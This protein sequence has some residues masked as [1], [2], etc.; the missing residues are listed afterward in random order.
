MTEPEKELLSLLTED[1]YGLWEVEVWL[2]VG[3]DTL[4]EIVSSLLR[5]QLIEWFTRE[6]DSA[7]AVALSELTET[8][9]SLEDPTAWVWP[10]RSERQYL[11]ATTEAGENVYFGSAVP[12]R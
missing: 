2:P 7:N 4:R 8:P 6:D 5:Q 10:G 1:Y 11:L 12:A 3:R 9:P